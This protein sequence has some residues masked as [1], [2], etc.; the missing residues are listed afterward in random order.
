MP[1]VTASAPIS[2]TDIG[3]VRKLEDA[4]GSVVRASPRRS[5]RR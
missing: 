4:V 3:A 2:S 1:A 5:A